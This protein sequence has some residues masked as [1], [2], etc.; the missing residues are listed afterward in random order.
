MGVMG[1]LSVVKSA[2]LFLNYFHMTNCSS[3]ELLAI[4]ADNSLLVL[5]GRSHLSTIITHT[6]D[7]TLAHIMLH[8]IYMYLTNF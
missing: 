6:R 3:I 2:Q 8:G 5:T 1:G 7:N 4:L